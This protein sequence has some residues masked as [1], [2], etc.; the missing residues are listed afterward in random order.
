MQLLM[1]VNTA[2][3]TEVMMLVNRGQI[4]ILM[5]DFGEEEV[6]LRKSKLILLILI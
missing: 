2:V 6:I 1:Q 5:E 3:F 4:S